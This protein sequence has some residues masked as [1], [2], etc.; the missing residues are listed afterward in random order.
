[1]TPLDPDS[2]ATPLPT[3]PPSGPRHLEKPDRDDL[4]LKDVLSAGATVAAGVHVVLQAAALLPNPTK[5]GEAGAIAEPEQEEE[6]DGD[7]SESDED[8]L[9]IDYSEVGQVL[10]EE[11]FEGAVHTGEVQEQ[12]VELFEGIFKAQVGRY[13]YFDCKWNLLMEADLPDKIQ[14]KKT[15]LEGKKIKF[16]E[17]KNGKEKTKLKKE[18]DQEIIQIEELM[19]EWHNEN[20]KKMKLPDD[21]KI[22]PKSYKQLGYPFVATPVLAGVKSEDLLGQHSLVDVVIDRLNEKTNSGQTEPVY[23]NNETK[24]IYEGIVEIAKAYDVPRAIVLGLGANESGF[25]KLA[26][27][28]A[29]AIG[30]YQFVAD[31]FVD[32]KKWIETHP[33]FGAKIRI[34]ILGDYE[35]SCI[36]RFVSA[37]L[38][39]ANYRRLTEELKDEVADFESRIRKIDSSFPAGTLTEIAIITAYNAGATRIK[40]CMARF[41]N[42]SDEEIKKRIGEAPYGVD[43]WLAVLAYAF[44]ATVEGSSTK[45]GPD[46]FMYAEKVLAM[47]ALIMQEENYL[48]IHSRSKQGGAQ[49]VES[50]EEVPDQFEEATSEKEGW[51]VLS[52]LRQAGALLTGAASFIMGGTVVASNVQKWG[53]RGRMPTGMTRRR[54]VQGLG[55]LAG[56]TVPAISATEVA[57]ETIIDAARD[58]SNRPEEETLSESTV[59]NVEKFP[60]SVLTDAKG[61]LDKLY[62]KMEE[63]RLEGKTGWTP[64]ELDEITK[65]KMPYQRELL[66]D[67]FENMLGTKFLKEFEDS[68]GQKPSKRKHLYVEGARIQTQYLEAEKKAG[69]IVPLSKNDPHAPYFP[70]QVGE[71]SGIGNNPKA[72]FTRKEFIPLLGSSVELVNYQVDLFNQNPGLYGITD[73]DFP[74]LPHILAIKVCGAQRSMEETADMIEQGMAART[75]PGTSAHWLD[76]AEDWASLATP[77][78][79]VVRLKEALLDKKGGSILV[80]AGG[81][82]PTTKVGNKSREIYFK[83]IGRALFSLRKPLKS[84]MGI[85]VQPLYEPSQSNWHIVLDLEEAKTEPPSQ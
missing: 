47:G 65:Y 64:D 81:K 56:L 53:R 83:M 11:K 43:V 18:I 74:V 25:N 42:L 55:A 40:G 19:Q 17:M 3:T 51:N 10:S 69:R 66:K 31:G 46:V 71:L 26:K 49:A 5:G 52:K 70:E 67:K 50:D 34:G 37:E 85:T 2:R 24:T 29:G 60:E 61:A 72:L 30:I 20:C 4:N 44:G 16:G 84:Q 48:K 68:I 80:P 32:A 38:F 21:Q 63:L 36:N 77:G 75:T 73:P 28:D 1:M 14:R 27:S 54:F 39:C 76:S 62:T 41:K 58:W 33:D 79:H 9:T 82:L 15:E 12:G 78:A 23:F 13:Y 45:V 57:V 6:G 59:V 8:K 35:S 7:I 22:M